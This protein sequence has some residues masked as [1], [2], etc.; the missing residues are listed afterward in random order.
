MSEKSMQRKGKGIFAQISY[1]I[2]QIFGI[3]IPPKK[4]KPALLNNEIILQ[5]DDLTTI[6]EPKLP[7]SKKMSNLF[8]EEL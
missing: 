4:G 2:Q 7:R 8:V 5:N 3:G 1:I 6:F